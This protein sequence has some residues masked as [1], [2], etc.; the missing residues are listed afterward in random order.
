MTGGGVKKAKLPPMPDPTP[1]PEDIDLAAAKKGEA[2]RR[3]IRSRFG[4][5]S[6]ILDEDNLG[7]TAQ[8][9]SPILGTVG[10]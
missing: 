3:K 10:N 6:T 1:V 4:R 7:T 2:E 9:K 5:A 8:A